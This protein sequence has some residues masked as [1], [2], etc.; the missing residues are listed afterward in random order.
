MIDVVDDPDFAPGVVVSVKPS[1]VLGHR[2]LP[3]DRHG[4]HEGVKT[5][6]VEALADV[7]ARGENNPRTLWNSEPSGSSS[8]RRSNRCP[9]SVVLLN[10]FKTVPKPAEA[11]RAAPDVRIAHTIVPFA[12]GLR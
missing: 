4:E 11:D 9:P 10:S 5:R 6:V 1:C 7:A 2:A 12:P 3:G 8:R